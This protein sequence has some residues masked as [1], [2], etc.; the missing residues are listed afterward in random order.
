MVDSRLV[1]ITGT[2]PWAVDC[3]GQRNG[4]STIASAKALKTYIH[5]GCCLKG[6]TVGGT[7][8]ISEWAG[9]GGISQQQPLLTLHF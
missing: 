2:A 4:H 1:F 5:G 6:G 9:G 7:A 8:G 3:Q